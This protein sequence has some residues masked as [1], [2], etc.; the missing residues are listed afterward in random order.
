[1]SRLLLLLLLMMMKMPKQISVLPVTAAVAGKSG[2]V[3][4]QEGHFFTFSLSFK[5]SENLLLS[6]NVCSKMLNLVIKLFL[7]KFKGGGAKILGQNS[8]CAHSCTIFSV[9]IL[10]VIC[11]VYRKIRIS[12]PPVFYPRRR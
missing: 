7:E 8:N 6:E 1:V 11:S 9:V 12:C 5:L 2:K 4:L 3:E 10:S